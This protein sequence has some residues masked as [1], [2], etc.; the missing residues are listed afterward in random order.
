M[1]NSLRRSRKARVLTVAAA[2]SVLIAVTV[3]LTVA[4]AAGGAGPSEA[5][6]SEA[7]SPEAGSIEA[8]AEQLAAGQERERA[9]LIANLA[10]AAEEAQGRMAQVLQELAAAVPVQ[11]GE[12]PAP[13][14]VSDVDRWNHELALAVSALE[15]VEEGT[16]EQTV[17]REAFIGAA[18]LLLST[19]AHYEQLLIAPAEERVAL[20]VTVAEQHDAAVRLWQAGAAQLDTLAVESGGSHVHLFLAPDGDPDAVP[21]E[22]REPEEPEE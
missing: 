9:E 4:L 6:P 15:T 20:T 17:A 12:G 3:V 14:S 13:A 1:R 11:E 8:I 21:A 16:S 22:F 19:A 7:G 5:G 10:E 18:Q 2:A